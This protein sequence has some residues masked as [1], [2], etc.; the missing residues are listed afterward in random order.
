MDPI[1]AALLALN[2]FQGYL[3]YEQSFKDAENIQK[4]GAYQSRVADMNARIANIQALDAIKK[5]DD[6]VQKIGVL[7]TQTIGT[8]RASL[9][10]QGLD[11]TSGSAA[12]IIAETSKNAE[13]DMVTA[14]NNAWRE[15]WGYKVSALSSTAQGEFIKAGA[16]QEAANTLLTGKYSLLTGG[17][18]GATNLIGNKGS[19]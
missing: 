18:R 14:R 5:G 9:A 6:T 3:G 13:L 1:S 12:D 19:I 2:V 17:I 15:S 11:I 4:R 8:Q 10:A 7:K 16:D